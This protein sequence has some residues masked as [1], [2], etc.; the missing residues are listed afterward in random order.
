MALR[1]QLD[2]TVGRKMSHLPREVLK[3][4]LS[5]DLSLPVKNIKR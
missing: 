2:Q 5:L 4:V 1:L 3:W